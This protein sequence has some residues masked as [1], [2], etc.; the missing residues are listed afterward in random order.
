[1]TLATQMT[2]LAEWGDGG[3]SVNFFLLLFLGIG[4]F[5]F[6]ARD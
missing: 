5:L 1:M 2:R 6:L 3:V 4:L